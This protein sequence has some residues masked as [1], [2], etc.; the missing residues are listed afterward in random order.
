MCIRD[1]LLAAVG[2][3]FGVLMNLAGAYLAISPDLGKRSAGRLVLVIV[4]IPHVASIISLLVLTPEDWAH[5]I[6]H[7]LTIVLIAAGLTAQGPRSAKDSG[8]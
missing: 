3:F 8:V 2:L 6:T 7:I 4:V 1:S 5:T